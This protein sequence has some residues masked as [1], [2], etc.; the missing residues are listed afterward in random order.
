MGTF[1]DEY[2]VQQILEG[3]IQVYSVLIDRYKHMVFTLA[4]KMLKNNEDAEE[5]AQDAFLK[6]YKGLANFK[7]DSKFSTWLY[8]ITYHRSLDYSKRN[9]RQLAT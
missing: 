4:K 9:K 5:V 3:N 6:A 8:R 2:Y 1:P 7:G